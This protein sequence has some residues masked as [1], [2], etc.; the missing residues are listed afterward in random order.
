MPAGAGLPWLVPAEAV[1]PPLQLQ[2]ALPSLLLA[3]LSV[4]SQ[5]FCSTVVM[6]A[7]YQRMKNSLQPTVISFQQTAR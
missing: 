6:G 1:T 3:S 2:L 4:G 5:S 7:H